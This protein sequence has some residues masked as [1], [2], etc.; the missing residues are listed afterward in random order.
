MRRLVA[1]WRGLSVGKLFGVFFFGSFFNFRFEPGTIT[2][3]G[4]RMQAI[5]PLSSSGNFAVYL[6]PTRRQ[7]QGLWANLAFTSEVISTF[8][9]A[10]RG[11]AAAVRHPRTW[12]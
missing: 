5:A 1:A 4:F 3:F 8:V 12:R 9:D 7:K 2:L 10:Y 6:P 11:G